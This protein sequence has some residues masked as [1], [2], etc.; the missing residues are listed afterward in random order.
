MDTDKEIRNLTYKLKLAL[1]KKGKIPTTTFVNNKDNYNSDT[2]YRFPCPRCKGRNTKRSGLTTQSERKSRLFC[3]DC[4]SQKDKTSFFV[5][6][7]QQIK[8]ILNNDLTLTKEKKS[9]FLYKY[10]IKQKINS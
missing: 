8:D 4:Q 7:N 9:F 1:A 3:L 6:S 5:L 10:L 2:I